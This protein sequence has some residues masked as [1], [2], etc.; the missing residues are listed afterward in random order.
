M[1]YILLIGLAISLIGIITY[2]IFWN[3]SN[4]L[5]VGLSWKQ[6]FFYG[7]QIYLI[8]LFVGSLIT[9]IVQSV[10]GHRA[11]EFSFKALTEIFGLMMYAIV[12]TIFIVLP[13]LVLGLKSISNTNKSKLQKE[14][15]FTTISFILVLLVNLMMTSFFKN[16]GFAFFISGFSVFGVITPWLFVRMRNVFSTETIS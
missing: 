7:F 1:G 15:L 8:T 3:K 10:F 2:F 11:V 9:L 16:L 4:E 14:I 13:F 5:T 12:F 6:S